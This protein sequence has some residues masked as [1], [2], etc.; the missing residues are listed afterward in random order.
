[1]S[2]TCRV[3]PKHRRTKGKVICIRGWRD[4]PAWPPRAS[5][6]GPTG[7]ACSTASPL[8][9]SLM[10]PATAATSS[11]CNLFGTRVRIS[12][13]TPLLISQDEGHLSGTVEH[14][15]FLSTVC[16]HKPPISG[17]GC[18]NIHRD[19]AS[20]FSQIV[21]FSHVWQHKPV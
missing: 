6:R 9:Q 10:P 18:P 4:Q 3:P 7:A 14:L 5:P 15:L 1:M 16:S 17:P 13:H 2:L 19:Q 20:S 21:S 11:S 8:P 12:A